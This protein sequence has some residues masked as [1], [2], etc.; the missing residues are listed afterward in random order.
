MKFG[1]QRPSYTT[2]LLEGPQALT[3]CVLVLLLTSQV[4]WVFTVVIDCVY[5]V[6][7]SPNQTYVVWQIELKTT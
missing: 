1:P 6:K 2:P 7:E 5:V 4:G 3:P